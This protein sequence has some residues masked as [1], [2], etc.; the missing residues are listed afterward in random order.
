MDLVC[1]AVDGTT[2]LAETTQNTVADVVVAH[3]SR[4]EA[5]KEPAH[6]IN[7]VR[8][9]GLGLSSESVR[10]VN[11]GVRTIAHAGLGRADSAPGN[12]SVPAETRSM[13]AP[14]RSDQQKNPRFI[15]DT[16]LGVV[17]GIVGDHVRTRDNDLDLGMTLRLDDR[18]FTAEDANEVLDGVATPKVAL[19][20]H[21]LAAT[22]TCWVMGAERAW[23]AP[24][25]HFGIRLRED[26][27]YTPIF[28]RYNSGLHI[29][30]NGRALAAM[31]E[32]LYENYPGR[33]E[34]LAI[35]G[36]SLGGL[37]ARSA[38]HYASLGSGGR[39]AW[40]D[41]LK[42]VI[43]V[44]TPHFGSPLAQAGHTLTAAMGAIETPATQVIASVSRLRSAAIKD[45]KEGY[46]VDEDWQTHDPDAWLSAAR[47]DIGFLTGVTY[48]FIGA[49]VS[50]NPESP[51]GHLVGDVL[52]RLSSSTHAHVDHRRASFAIERP[53]L[54]GL[55]H[56][57]IQND[58]QVYEQIRLHLARPPSDATACG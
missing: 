48:V 1:D 29:S 31:M 45:L 52:V 43:T 23:G 38:T 51:L 40:L 24:D 3:L 58:P 8:R 32:R 25:Q 5:M 17:N 50:A 19:F 28:V 21:G 7:E 35:I 55:N 42:H 2:R 20:V 36:H 15:E 57:Q 26:L 13:P 39:P 11:Q 37:V 47:S 9:L 41:A 44:G 14:M 34:R 10:A 33:L 12:S 54:G 22:E 30:E 49:S 18:Y 27:G 16:L 56:L 53:V 4:L 46:L 6:L